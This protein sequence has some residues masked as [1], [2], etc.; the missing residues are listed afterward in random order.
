MRRPKSACPKAGWTGTTETKELSRQSS[1][2]SFL[3]IR[4]PRIH[5]S[6]EQVGDQVYQNENQAEKEDASLNRREI[7]FVDGGQNVAARAGP[8]EDGFSQ[9]RAGEV[10][11]EVQPQN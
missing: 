1:Q 5:S 4:Y 8:G 11:A 7:A 2:V 10:P 3:V 6:I 9:D